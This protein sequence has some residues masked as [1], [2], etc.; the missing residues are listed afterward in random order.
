MLHI[1]NDAKYN[2]NL[3]I[4]NDRNQNYFLE[5]TSCDIEMWESTWGL[6]NRIPVKTSVKAMTQTLPNL[7]SN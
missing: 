3:I 6:G 4:W 2:W 7:D 1:R 5:I